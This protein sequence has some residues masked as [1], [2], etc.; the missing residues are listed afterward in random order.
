[1]IRFTTQDSK[2]E[3]TVQKNQFHVKKFESTNQEPSGVMVGQTIVSTF[4]YLL[5]GDF[6]RFGYITTTEVISIEDV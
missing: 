3:V 1:M 2:Y 6:A 5:V 4:I